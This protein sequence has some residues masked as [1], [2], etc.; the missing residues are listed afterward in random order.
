MS[1]KDHNTTEKSTTSNSSEEIVPIGL[2]EAVRARKWILEVPPEDQIFA[3]YSDKEKEN[4]SGGPY[5]IRSIVR[6]ELTKSPFRR[7]ILNTLYEVKNAFTLLRVAMEKTPKFQNDGEGTPFFKFDPES[8]PK[9]QEIRDAVAFLTSLE[10]IGIEKDGFKCIYR[11]TPVDALAKWVRNKSPGKTS[12]KTI[13]YNVTSPL[14]IKVFDAREKVPTTDE[15][16]TTIKLQMLTARMDKENKPVILTDL[17]YD[18]CHRL[19]QVKSPYRHSFDLVSKLEDQT[20]VIESVENKVQ[21]LKSEVGTFLHRL[22]PL[23]TAIRVRIEE[24]FG[25]DAVDLLNDYIRGRNRDVRTNLEHQFNK[26]YPEQNDKRRSFGVDILNT[27]EP[28]TQC[29]KALS[30]FEEISAELG[31]LSSSLKVFLN[32]FERVQEDL[33][34]ASNIDLLRRIQDAERTLDTVSIVSSLKR[35][36]KLLRDESEGEDMF[37]H[38]Y[39]DLTNKFGDLLDESNRNRYS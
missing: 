27:I 18:I 23:I 9:V 35:Y 30:T 15:P 13:R 33:I 24:F 38:Y 16:L 31:N 32:R 19:F 7:Q 5:D 21:K 12:L 10:M 8:V 26:A 4:F 25:R 22:D 34:D 17:G 1:Q 3:A 2:Q 14:T 28:I 29:G 11:H 37:F 6:I 39:K 20:K 36:E